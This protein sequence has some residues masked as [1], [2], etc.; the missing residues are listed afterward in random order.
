MLRALLPLPPPDFR[1]VAHGIRAG[2]ATVLNA[3][4]VPRAVIQAWGWWSRPA[5]D[6]TDGHYAATCVNAM[7]A[8]SRR[9]HMVV[10]S[11]ESPGFTEVVSTGGPLPATW[12]TPT[13]ATAVPPAPSSVPVSAVDDDASSSDEVG[14]NCGVRPVGPRDRRRVRPQVRPARA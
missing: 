14:E 5:G 1:L 7:I 6:A 10:I 4:R 2:S 13:D 3:L 11:P 12:G 8:A 9:M